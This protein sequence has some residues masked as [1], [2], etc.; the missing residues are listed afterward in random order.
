MVS[1]TQG[2][3]ETIVFIYNDE[4]IEGRGGVQ[5]V[6]V[7]LAQQFKEMGKRII[8]LST[9]QCKNQIV[10]KNDLISVHITEK[11]FESLLPTTLKFLDNV[12]FKYM[13]SGK[14]T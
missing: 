13:L 12:F 4:F 5:N 2:T 3:R 11:T 6:S 9:D 14:C 8:F 7:K 10:V 1:A